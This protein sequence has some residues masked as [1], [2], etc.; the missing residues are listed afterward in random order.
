MAFTS[1]SKIVKETGEPTEFEDQLAQ[2]L[3]DLQ[4]HSSNAR[5]KAALTSLYINA[6]KELD[7]GD[8]KKA[9]TLFVPHPSLKHFHAIQDALVSELEKKLPGRHVVIIAQRR[10]LKKPSK[11]NRKAQQK[12]PRSRTL[13]A[14]Q[15]AILEDLVYPGEIIDRRIRYRLDGTRAQKVSLDPREEQSLEHKLETFS[16]VYK[17]LTGKD[18]TFVFPAVSESAARQGDT[19]K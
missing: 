16:G 8:G 6:A 5:L 15:D 11:N 7:L 9:V 13:T 17:R 3:F 1:R 14:V 4:T 18:V 19:S 12:R 10:I 2:Y